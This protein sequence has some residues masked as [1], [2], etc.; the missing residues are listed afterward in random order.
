MF[1]TTPPDRENI[2]H[3]LNMELRH[4]EVS[5]IIKLSTIIDK[6]EVWRKL[7]EEL[8]KK[9][10]R[11]FDG[12]RPCPRLDLTTENINLIEQQ[13]SCGKSSGLALLKHWSITG[14]R[15][16][17]VRT[18]IGYL[19]VCNLKW[20]EEYVYESILG[21]QKMVPS[22][23]HANQAM[24]QIAPPKPQVREIDPAFKFDSLDKLIDKLNKQCTRYNFSE[25][26]SSSNGFCDKPFDLNSMIGTKIGEG[27][28]SSV[29]RCKTQSLPSED[30]DY[31]EPDTVAAKLL[32][33]ECNMDY[34]ANE[35]NLMSRISH[36]NLVQLLGVSFGKECDFNPDKKLDE[37]SSKYEYICL[38][39][40]FL[41]N[42]SLLD[43]IG[44]G[45]I[46]QNMRFLS[47]RERLNIAL[48][49][50]R[51]IDYLHSSSSSPLIHRDIKTANIFI[52]EKVEP[53]LGDFTLL[54]ELKNAFHSETDIMQSSI[55]GTSV[56]MAPET[57]QGDVS[58][59]SDAFSF[60]IVLLELITGLRPCDENLDE[61][62]FSHVNERLSDIE[63]ELGSNP[64]DE[65]V[66]QARNE[67]LIEILDQKAG[68]WDFSIVSQ[69]FEISQRLTESR[70][71]NR[72]NVKDLIDKLEKI[73]R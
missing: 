48:K 35:I 57:F 18:L 19:N 71:A 17:T 14:R 4:I 39:Y 49:T 21:L 32:K 38:V 36:P 15:R 66:I 12:N 47:W 42:G 37:G 8:T 72:A 26:Y 33:S 41:Q 68:E 24:L 60:G 58:S 6:G 11:S 53:K 22:I 10:A 69:L 56:Y 46:S 67:F 52:D 25:I 1:R 34:L 5:K 65:K 55:I 27:R 73:C 62:L 54:V 64:N 13:M 50:A 61:D 40:P 51:A 30:D 3:L 29:Y 23:Q 7:L 44:S 70:K 20:A 16:P 31:S 63:D 9:Q 59:K 45:L 2:A 28:F 43:C